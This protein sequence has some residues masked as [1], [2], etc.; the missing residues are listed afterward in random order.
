MLDKL[1]KE[2]RKRGYRIWVRYD[3]QVHR[4]LTV[5]EGLE[6]IGE[7]TQCYVQAVNQ[8]KEEVACF[9]V[10]GGNE[11][12]EQILDHGITQLSEAILK[13]IGSDLAGLSS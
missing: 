12:H 10:K 8:R 6:K 4:D 9:I 7:F 13:A 2:I 11:P 1:L 5:P 3:G